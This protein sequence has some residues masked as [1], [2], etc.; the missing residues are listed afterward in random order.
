MLKAVL[1][2][3]RPGAAGFPPSV[4]GRVATHHS[5][6]VLELP[7]SKAVSVCTSAHAAALA[8]T[9]CSM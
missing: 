9:A 5:V 1:L 8:M 6:L 3:C 7:S 2:H 4:Q